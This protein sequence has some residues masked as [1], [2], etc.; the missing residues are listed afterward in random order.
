MTGV[1]K[2][3]AFQEQLYQLYGRPENFRGIVYPDTGHAY[4][5]K[6]WR[7][8]LDWLDRRLVPAQH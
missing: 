3:N 7:E 4:T 8:T 2:I 5:P 6:M 1:R